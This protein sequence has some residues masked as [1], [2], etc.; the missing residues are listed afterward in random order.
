MRQ[1]SDAFLLNVAEVSATLIG[2]FLVGVFFYAETGFRRLGMQR[3]VMEPYMRSGT[4]I[5]LV[6]YAL[7][8]LLSLTLV[9]LDPA[10]N[11]V[12][13]ALL[14]VVLL[15]AN[16]DTLMRVRALAKVTRSSVFLVNEL[17]GTAAVLVLVALPWVLG[18]F[19][20]TRED[21]T[22]AILLSLG[23]GFLSVSALVL[24]IFDAA[25]DEAAAPVP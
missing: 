9:V 16:V 12:L 18:G 20:P 10:W 23:A 8:L 2:L 5:V 22:W 25:G 21:L 24:S 11:R 17:V 4:R 19:E 1:V 6:L 14:S 13:F 7:P 3:E 15:V